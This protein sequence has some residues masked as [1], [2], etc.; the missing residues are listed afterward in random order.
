MR[1]TVTSHVTLDGVVQSNGKP[2]PELKD[3]F[4]QGGWQVPYLDQELAE[5]VAG[6]IAEADAFLF[7]RGT[8]DLFVG[9][10]PKVTDPN[11]PIALRISTMPKYVAS[12]SVETSTGRTPCCCVGTSSKRCP[13]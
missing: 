6:W 2:E 4:H 10:W 9:H 8:Y 3:G 5:L 1:L 11:D 12:H 7:G 13:T